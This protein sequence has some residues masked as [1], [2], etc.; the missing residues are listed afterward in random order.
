[1]SED[2]K[3]TG[4]ALKEYRKLMYVSQE[5]VAAELGYGAA[6]SVCRIEALEYVDRVQYAEVI[7][8]VEKAAAKK[9]IKQ[10]A[11]PA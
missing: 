2:G 7:V 11:V 6:S 5:E 1:M 8:A 3:R 9:R 4:Q 10:A